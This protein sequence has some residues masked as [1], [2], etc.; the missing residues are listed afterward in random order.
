MENILWRIYYGE[1][2][3]E[4]ILWRIYYGE[5]IIENICKDKLDKLNL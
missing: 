4:N 2:I 1:Y 3:M 5:Y